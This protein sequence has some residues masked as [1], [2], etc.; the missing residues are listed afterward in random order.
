M[1][2]EFLL[3]SVLLWPMMLHGCNSAEQQDGK[4]NSKE[5]AG[6]YKGLVMAGYQ[7]WFNAEGDGAD[8]G[9]YHYQKEGR[10]EPGFCTVDM[11]PEMSEYPDKYK[12]SF[13][14]KDGTPAYVFSSYDE[15]TVDLH[16]KW[17]KEYGIDGVFMQRFVSTIKDPKGFAHYDKILSSAFASAEKYGRIICIMYDLSGMNAED[18]QKVIDDWKYL[19]KKYGL[20][21]TK[22]PASYLSHKGKP[23][24]AVWGIG[25]NDNRKY[26][27]KEADKIISF[28]KTDRI[29][30]GVAV[31]VGVPTYWREQ[32][33]DAVSDAAFHSLILKADIVH[34]WHVGRYKSETEYDAFKKI[35]A[36]DISWCKKNGLDYVPTVFPGFS[37]KNM[38]PASVT[39]M[40]PRDKGNFL[41]KQFS[42][43]L[44]VGAEMIYVAMFDEIDE[45]TA[46][47]KCAHQVP[48]VK[49][50]QV[51]EG[52][53]LNV[54]VPLEEEVPND[55]YLWLTGQAA[56]MLRKET[57]FSNKMPVRD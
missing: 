17:M 25:F 6:S 38:Y 7:A 10:F 35:I 20:L 47:F 56:L 22:K 43:A 39:D 57:P 15:S 51:V 27:L 52:G 41:W 21:G 49:P 40:I 31:Q 5:F 36:D 30:G 16:F 54:F 23:L 33:N 42:G 3:L 2:T 18:Y 9:W 45:G 46:I 14:L 34:P 11:W 37:W 12:T 29:Y 24:V 26:G 32:K 53:I 13:N 1:K 48:V 4:E 44:S 28:L 50:A 19:A 55:H 8:R